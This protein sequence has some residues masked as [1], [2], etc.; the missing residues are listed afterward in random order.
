VLL[1][2]IF[3]GVMSKFTSLTNRM[4]PDPGSDSN[5]ARRGFE[6]ESRLTSLTERAAFRNN[7]K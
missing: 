5:E 4:L 6:S 7:E 3:P 2:E 1:N